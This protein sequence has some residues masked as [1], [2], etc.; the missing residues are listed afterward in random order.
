MN[1]TLNVLVVDDEH[2]AVFRLKDML[3]KQAPPGMELA[4]IGEFLMPAEAIK[5]A[6]KTPIHLAFL[7]IEMPGMN[8]FELADELLKLQPQMYIVFT[9]AYKDYAIKAFEIDAIDYLL[10]PVTSNRLDIT[11]NRIASSPMISHG[12]GHPMLK[13]RLGCF[14]KLHY[15][16][17]CGVEQLFPWKTLKA[18]ELFSYLLLN[19]DKV[20]NKQVLIDLLWPQYNLEKATT[21]LHT[22]IYQIRKV[23]KE[24]GMP[25][26]IKYVEG[27]YSMV[28]GEVEIDV[29]V[30]EIAVKQAPAFTPH[31]VEQHTEIMNMYQG[32]F[33][34]QSAYS[35][36]SL[37]Q[38]R[39]QL[40]WF[41]H[42]NQL[43]ELYFSLSRYPQA[44]EVYQKMIHF[45]PYMEAGYFG[46]MQINAILHY[47][48]EVKKQYELLCEALSELLDITPSHKVKTWYENWSTFSQS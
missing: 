19:R 12:H 30:W 7:D 5:V 2:L 28:M 1:R 23:L 18:Q 25:I 14:Q 43:A 10:K 48:S 34:A 44:I 33:L 11:L 32:H 22:A 39:L 6:E 46:L 47:P 24:V 20:I 45:T 38:E 41:N 16:D 8:G 27:G 17:E 31:T 15:K 3:K 13:P 9:T 26:E 42:A 35:W 29:Q 40:L 36:A 21:Q 4:L 37:E